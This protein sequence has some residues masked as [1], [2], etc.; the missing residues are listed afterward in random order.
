MVGVNPTSPAYG[1]GVAGR[2]KTIPKFA[3]LPIEGDQGWKFNDPDPAVMQRVHK[4]YLK[5]GEFPPGLQ[6]TRLGKTPHKAPALQANKNR[7]ISRGWKK[8][9]DGR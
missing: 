8:P 7:A 2:P 6:P 9:K 3:L 4:Q 5:K 1:P